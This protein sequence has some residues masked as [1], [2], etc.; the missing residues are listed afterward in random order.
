M[1]ERLG[2]G[3]AVDLEADMMAIHVNAHIIENEKL[4]FGAEIGGITEAGFL[5]VVFRRFCDGARVTV[6]RFFRCGI[7][8]IAKNLDGLLRRKRVITDLMRV[9]HDDHVG[10]VNGLPAANG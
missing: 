1:V 4:G 9:R 2:K 6:V 10:L 5:E 3:A 7:I 8:D